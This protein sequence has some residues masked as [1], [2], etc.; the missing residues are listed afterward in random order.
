MTAWEI[1]RTYAR[2]LVGIG[3]ALAFAVCILFPPLQPSAAATL[4]VILA[5]AA[6][7]AAPVRLSKFSYLNQN[8]VPVLVGALTLG[9][10]PVVLGLVVGILATD[11][12]IL[13]KPSFAAAVNA[14][15]EVIAFVTAYGAYAAVARVTGVHGL[16]LDALPAAITLVGV[17]FFA[18]RSLFYFTMLLRA[19]LESEERLLILRYEIVSYLL[20]VLATLMVLGALATLA[21]TGWIAVMVVLGFVGLLTKKIVEEAIAAEYLNKVHVMEA[22]V[23]RNV[24]LHDSFDQIERL[25]N[26]LLDWG[27][28][29]IYRLDDGRFELTYRSVV[30]RPNRDDPPSDYQVLRAEALASGTPVVINDATV[31]TRVQN[32]D[33][34]A[35]CLVFMPLTFG[36]E[37]IGTLELEHH[38]RHVYRA[39]ELAAM[40]TLASQIATAIHI[41]ELRRPLVSTVEQIGNQIDALAGIAESLRESATSLA[42]VAGAISS[43]VAEEELFVTAGLEATE[44]LSQASR[45]VV[46]EGEK[47]SQVS[48]VAAQVATRNRQT[49]AEAIDRLVSVHQFVSESA[50]QVGQLGVVTRQITGFIGSIHEIADL[51]NLIALNAAIE[52]ARAGAEGK[53]FA[54][55]ADEVRDLAA[56]SAAAARD[57]GRLVSA[58]S[59]QVTEISSQMD[60]G[61]QVVSGVEQLSSNAANAL[62][63]IVLSAQEVGGH[64]TRI[65]ATATAQEGP[66]QKLKEQ[67]QYL[68][69]ISRRTQGETGL[70]TDRAAEASRGQENLE[71]S[72]GQLQHVADHLQRITKHFAV[73]E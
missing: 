17:Y 41:S 50:E 31:D 26:R 39:R 11:T 64:A 45:D 14:G 43:R 19:K 47:A 25:A 44:S 37:T 40:S 48:E 62:D 42:S 34:K 58:I 13:R 20:T 53:G 8:G 27:D 29:R 71:A 70:L 12:F 32:V 36:D 33:P 28:L 56:Q 49:I 55:V 1:Q 9:P 72:I 7:R 6:L 3:G 18:S 2:A 65:A 24:A 63:E 10:G 68:A 61:Q 5:I 30:G 38:K 57:A 16:S 59:T 35:R 73:G 22:T 15:R 54:V 60:R 66:F 4:A 46:L 69:E 52:A 67:I 21:P 51:T 23:T